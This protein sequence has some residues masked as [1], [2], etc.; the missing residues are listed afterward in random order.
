MAPRGVVRDLDIW[1]EYDLD[2]QRH[3]SGGLHYSDLGAM[4]QSLKILE[5]SDPDYDVTQDLRHTLAVEG[6]LPEL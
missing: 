3:S 4:R 2:P 1:D 5:D 6:R